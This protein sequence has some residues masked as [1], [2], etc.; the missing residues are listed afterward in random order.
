MEQAPALHCCMVPQVATLATLVGIAHSSANRGKQKP[1]VTT[2]RRSENHKQTLSDHKKP[3][4]K[5]L[6]KV[7]RSISFHFGGSLFAPKQIRTISGGLELMSRF[8]FEFCRCETIR[9]FGMLGVQS[10][11]MWLYMCLCFGLFAPTHFQVECCCVF[12]DS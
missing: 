12:D 7:K 9:I 3:T 1:Q 2:A 10:H 5:P 8:G 4:I 6:W 11:T